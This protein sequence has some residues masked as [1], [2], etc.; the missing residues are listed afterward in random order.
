MNPPD[1]IYLH[2]THECN[3]HCI[4]CAIP[5]GKPMGKELS[6]EEML[7]LLKDICELNPKKVIFTG[8]EPLLRNDLLETA[9][10]I[11]EYAGNKIQ[12]CVNTN[13]V[14][15]NQN[16]VKKFVEIF[17]EIRISIDGFEE[18]NDS[19]RTRGSFSSAMRAFKYVRGAGGDPIA[20]ITV[21]S[22]NIHSLRDFMHFLLRNGIFRIHI[23]PLKPAGRALEREEL[24]CDNKQMTKIVKDFWHE[25]FGLHM[26][27]RKK[28]LNCGIGRYITIYPDGT[29][30]PCYMVAFPEFCIGNVRNQ[31]LY[32][33]YQQSGL[34]NKLRNFHFSEIAQCAECFKELSR[35]K[36][37]L[38]IHA[39]KREF[40]EQLLDLLD[41][42]DKGQTACNTV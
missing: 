17:D 33:I 41:E 15:I 20:Y 19:L 4:Y 34:M 40:R 8:G 16:N 12:L 11:K 39:Q 9:F 1:R 3:L 5:S 25:S 6:T 10:A 2:I 36:T 23:S 42:S 27:E 38:G 30:F 14:L 35:E 21:T 31:R 7:S 24:L 28:E 26:K 22:I 13:G 18:I 32:S 29:V 37:C